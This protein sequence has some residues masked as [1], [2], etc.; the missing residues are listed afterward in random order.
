MTSDLAR[1][2]I[3]TLQLVVESDVRMLP[4]PPTFSSS[5]Y[6][7]EQQT[8]LTAWMGLL[9]QG[10][11]EVNAAVLKS[12]AAVLD[13]TEDAYAGVGDADFIGATV[14]LSASGVPILQIAQLSQQSV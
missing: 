6:A 1:I 9:R 13:K 7:A 4:S 14:F 11:A 12:V 8:L 5:S 2:S 3:T 10:K